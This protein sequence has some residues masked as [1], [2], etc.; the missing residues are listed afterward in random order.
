MSNNDE[1][2]HLFAGGIGGT[3]GAICT[4]PLEVV[5]TR[6]QSSNSGF[7][8]SLTVKAVHAPTDKNTN[9]LS[10]FKKNKKHWQRLDRLTCRPVFGSPYSS[11]NYLLNHPSYTFGNA[12]PILYSTQS[13]PCRPVKTKLTSFPDRAGGKLIHTVN[14]NVHTA[15]IP[16]PPV[17]RSPATV[18]ITTCLKHIWKHE[19]PTG[20]FRGLGPNLIGVA[21]SR[22]I[23]FWSY[24]TTKKKLNSRLPLANRDAPFVH[25]MSAASAGF[26]SSC[27]TNPIWLIKTR[28]Q[29]DRSQG[30]LVSVIK[31][32]RSEKGIPGFWKG[33]T[34][35]WWGI[36]ETMIHWALYEYLKKS[37]NNYNQ[38]H[39]DQ[40]RNFVDFAGYMM[41]GATAKTCATCVAYPHEVARTRMRESGSKYKS[42]WQTLHLVYWEDGRRGLYRGMM[43]QLVR[44][45]PNTAIM[46]FTYEA[47]V[48]MLTNY[49]RSGPSSTVI[50][51]TI[52]NKS[53]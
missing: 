37:W 40:E 15:S 11:A 24:S 4:C 51:S 3:A 8:T 30:G 48:Y 50:N 49:F 5:K 32:I 41:C 38:K 17:H 28:L 22:A 18:S 46:M 19:G 26:I 52:S 23:Y 1:F 27:V 25:V 16:E 6:L 33:V 36:S 44:Q 43:T 10:K 35:S 47:T 13:Q 2:I 14:R 20:L 45:I 53:T 31:N 29:L 42:F 12:T 21:P 34:A 39:Q 7:D 9:S